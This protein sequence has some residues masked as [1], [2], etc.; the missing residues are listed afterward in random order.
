[1]VAPEQVSDNGARVRHGDKDERVGPI[2]ELAERRLEGRALGFIRE[3]KV[4][5]E[6][7]DL[8][9]SSAAAGRILIRSPDMQNPATPRCH[10]RRAAGT[11]VV[12]GRRPAKTLWVNVDGR[13][14]IG[15]AW[16]TP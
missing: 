8:L 11:G 5:Y 7:P 10:C 15:G 2:E 1:M 13:K 9:T 16:S 3:G 6:G 4:L 14:A 12:D